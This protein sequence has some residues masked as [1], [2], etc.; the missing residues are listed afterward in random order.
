[1]SDITAAEG[2][3]RKGWDLSTWAASI[4]WS[5]GRN[6]REWLLGLRERIEAVQEAC[7][8]A[9]YA[10]SGMTTAAHHVLDDDGGDHV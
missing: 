8:D 9:G 10:G 3:M 4:D 1:M 6:T 2:A 5:G 7:I